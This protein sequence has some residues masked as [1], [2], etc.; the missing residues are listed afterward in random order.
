MIEITANRATPDQNCAMDKSPSGPPTTAPAVTW[1]EETYQR[2][3][4]SLAAGAVYFLAMVAAGWLFG[5]IREFATRR[6]FNPLA[7]VLIEAIPLLVIMGLSSGW[8]MR[9]L[10]VRDRAG[11]RMLVGSV[12]VTLVIS[13]EFVGGAMVRGWGLYETLTN[14]TTAPGLVFCALL[15]AALLMPLVEPFGRKARR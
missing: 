4:R 11:D 3:G 1:V 10:R 14:M 13:S 5:P 8:A 6:G 7:A 15:V 12:A 9:W 2:A